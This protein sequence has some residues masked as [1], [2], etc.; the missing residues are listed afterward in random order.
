M[1]QLLDSQGSTGRKQADKITQ[2]LTYANLHEQEKY[3]YQGRAVSLESG[4]V[5]HK[6]LFPGLEN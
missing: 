3:D 2:L 1:R 6:G 4:A 5:N